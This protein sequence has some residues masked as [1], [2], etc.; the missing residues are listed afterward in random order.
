MKLSINDVA[1]MGL[2]TKT[3]GLESNLGTIVALA[4]QAKAQGK[5]ALFTGELSATGVEGGMMLA[6]P[7]LLE[8]LNLEQLAAQLP[9]DFSLTDYSKNPPL[10]LTKVF[11]ELRKHSYTEQSIKK[12]KMTAL[13]WI[14]HLLQL[15][16]DI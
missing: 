5:K 11:P 10:S 12:I 4:R 2:N 1:A 13:I 7:H 3:F 8:S 16:Y 9:E 6:H 14:K 15:T